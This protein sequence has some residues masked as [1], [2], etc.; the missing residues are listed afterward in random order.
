MSAPGPAGSDSEVPPTRR[1]WRQTHPSPPAPRRARADDLVFA[2]SSWLLP[3]AAT[4]MFLSAVGGRRT[5]LLPEQS[6]VAVMICGLVV[7]VVM[8]VVIARSAVRRAR[9]P[10]SVLG[11]VVLGVV[12]ALSIAIVVSR[13]EGEIS[14]PIT[15]MI[16]VAAAAVC[17]SVVAV[18]I[19]G[20]LRR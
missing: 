1:Q 7:G 14:S 2:V 17:L 5:S 19:D 9:A 3:L 11:V 6:A 18:V 13:N 12:A 10:L 8:L 15:A 16:V 20:T 4:G